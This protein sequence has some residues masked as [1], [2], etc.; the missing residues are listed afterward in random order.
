MHYLTILPLLVL[1]TLLHTFSLGQPLFSFYPSRNGLNV[2]KYADIFQQ[3]F[4]QIS[5]GENIKIKMEISSH[6]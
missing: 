3:V 4:V 5:A 2:S 1:H 6:P